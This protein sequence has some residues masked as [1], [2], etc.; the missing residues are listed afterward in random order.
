MFLLTLIITWDLKRRLLGSLSVVWRRFS[1][2]PLSDLN[3]SQTDLRLFSLWPHRAIT[4]R[5]GV[6]PSAPT[7]TTSCLRPTISPCVCGRGRGS[8]SS[9]RRSGRWWAGWECGCRRFNLYAWLASLTKP[10]IFFFYR[11][12][13]N[14]K[15]NSRRAWLKGMFLWWDLSFPH[16]PHV[17]IV[18][19]IYAQYVSVLP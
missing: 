13:R 2:H 12:D 14:E 1:F 7:A 17:L 10:I 6:W 15:Q 18:L 11:P 3:T 19:Y 8:P 16:F 9:W 5:S 4:A